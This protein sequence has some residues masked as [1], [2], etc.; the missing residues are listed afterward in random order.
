MTDNHCHHCYQ[1]PFHHRARILIWPQ[2][3]TQ[4][5]EK[6]TVKRAVLRSKCL[7]YSQ[8]Q[9]K[10]HHL[11]FQTPPSP[12]NYF[13]EE[14][15]VVRINLIAAWIEKWE[16]WPIFARNPMHKASGTLSQSAVK[17]HLQPW[18]MPAWDRAEQAPSAPHRHHTGRVQPCAAL[19]TPK[20]AARKWFSNQQSSCLPGLCS[21][22]WK[23]H[24]HG[25]LH[26]LLHPEQ[27]GAHF[28][29]CP[30]SNTELNKSAWDFSKKPDKGQKVQKGKK[31]KVLTLD[32]F[33]PQ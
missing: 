3:F 29:P 9:V 1:L 20:L 21:F 22:S 8:K 31:K 7:H 12:K 17:L 11:S 25:V 32:S 5:E 30:D 19:P 14:L 27:R 6:A 33:H 16:L 15:R 23:L 4:T 18:A 26:S 13:Q 28:D 24:D 2:Q 10:N